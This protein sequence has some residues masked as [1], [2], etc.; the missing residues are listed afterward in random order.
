MPLNAD[1]EV[2]LRFALTP[3]FG[4]RSRVKLLREFGSPEAVLG[5]S[6]ASLQKIL[7]TDR[8]I[9]L[10]ES[11]SRQGWTELSL[12]LDWLAEPGNRLLTL[13]DAAFPPSLLDLPDAPV[14]LFLKGDPALLVR[15]ALALVGSRQATPQGLENAGAFAQTLSCAGYT[16]ISGLAAGIDAAAHQGGL[17]GAGSTIAVVGTGL[18]RVY[19][20]TNRELAHQIAEQGVLVSEFALGSAPIAEHFPRRNRLI[21]ALGLGCLVVE[22]TLGSG[23]LITAR[24]AADLGREV[25]AIPGS[26][27]SP[28]S[29]GCHQLIKQGAKLVESA[30][31]VLEELAVPQLA[32]LN[33]GPKK[34]IQS[35]DPVLDKMGWDPVDIDTLALRSGLSAEALSATLLTLELDG[36][37]SALPGGRY[38][39]KG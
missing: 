17:A 34:K 22:A 1:A 20:A 2:W 31:D 15:P 39:R 10:A 30:Q 3:G 7:E 16:I 25:F 32:G 36:H 11:G 23:S 38:Q 28:Q 26:I 27:H 37:V 13:A 12:H 8:A 14:V 6:V 33:L 35:A 19:P 24:Q 18:D 5:A 21:A 4:S 29:K 9:A